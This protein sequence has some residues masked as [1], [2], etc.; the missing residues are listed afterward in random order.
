M[1]NEYLQKISIFENAH[2]SG[3]TSSKVLE[4]TTKQ[5]CCNNSIPH[6]LC[7]YASKNLLPIYKHFSIIQLYQIKVFCE[8]TC[9]KVHQ[10]LK[11]Y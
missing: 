11:H 6:N 9:L 4:D 2:N 7:N 5:V 8:Y 3:T 10:S 1:S